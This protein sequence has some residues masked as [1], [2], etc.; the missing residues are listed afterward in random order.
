MSSNNPFVEQAQEQLRDVVSSPITQILDLGVFRPNYSGS[1]AD[2]EKEV[3]V[4]FV[5]AILKSKGRQWFTRDF[6]RQILADVAKVDVDLITEDVERQVLAYMANRILTEDLKGNTIPLAGRAAHCYVFLTE[7][8]WDEFVYNTISHTKKLFAEAM[9][10]PDTRLAV[11]IT[12]LSVTVGLTKNISSL[13]KELQE[14]KGENEIPISILEINSFIG[15]LIPTY[16][17]CA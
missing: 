2:F 5:G 17:K 16:M 6:V 15:L 10:K 1:A 8:I 9:Y 12:R 4:I 7:D 3:T 13:L 11:E 14:E